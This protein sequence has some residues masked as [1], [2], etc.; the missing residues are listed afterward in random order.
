MILL[1][2]PQAAGTGCDGRAIEMIEGLAPTDAR[3]AAAAPDMLEALR[4]CRVFLA[5]RIFLAG[6]PTSVGLLEKVDAALAGAGGLP[7]PKA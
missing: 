4:A 2:I 5:C 6:D 3:L 1:D 7:P